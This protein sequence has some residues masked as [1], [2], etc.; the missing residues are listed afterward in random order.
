MGQSETEIRIDLDEGWLET[1]GK[2][3]I[4]VIVAG[5]AVAAFVLSGGTLAMLWTAITTVFSFLSATGLMGIIVV[6]GVTCAVAAYAQEGFTDEMML[7]L[8]SISPEEIFKG[9][10]LLFDID[11]F[12]PIENYYVRLEDGTVLNITDYDDQELVEEIGDKNVDSYFYRKDGKEVSKSKYDDNDFQNDLDSGEIIRTSKQNSSLV[13]QKLVS[14]WYNAIRNI[15]IV[16]SMSVLLYIGIRMLLSTVSQD[17]ARY[18][19]MLV[20]WVVS[21]CLLFFM[22]YIMAFSLTVVD[23]ITDILNIST[24]KTD[25]MVVLEDDEDEKISDA[26]IDDFG[27]EDSVNEDTDPKQI[28]WNTNLMG[29]VRIG[30]QMQYGDSSFVGLG[31]CFLILVFYTVYFTFVYLRRLLY[32]AFLTMIAPLVAL[33]YPI[34]KI[35]DG[36]AQAFDRWLKEYIFNLL[37]QPLH[38]LLYTVLVTSAFD[39]AGEN[40]LYCLVAIGFLI[41]AE[42]LMRSFF[43]FEKASTP[44]SMAGAAVGAGLVSSGIQKLLHGG[45]HIGKNSGDGSDDGGTRS[46]P[47]IG[48]YDDSN[49]GDIYG[50]GNG[51]NGEEARARMLDADDERFGTSDWDPQE[52]DRNARELNNGEGM[53]YSD[54]EYMQILRDSGYTNDEIAQLMRPEENKSGRERGEYSVVGDAGRKILSTRPGRKIAGATGRLR[55]GISGRVGQV[56]GAVGNGLNTVTNTRPAQAIGRAANYL[57]NSKEGEFVKGVGRVAKYTAKQGVRKAIKATPKV[58]A[59]AAAGATLA[60]GGAALGIATGDPSNIL[61]YGGGLGAAGVTLGSGAAGSLTNRPKSATQIARERAFYGD[62]YDEHREKQ[63]LDKLKRDPQVREKLEKELSPTQVKNLV[64]GDNPLIDQY[65]KNGI[66]DV[67][68]IITAEKLKT[69]KM[70]VDGKQVNVANNTEHAIAIVKDAGRRGDLT[71]MSTKNRN[72]ILQDDMKTLEA[73]GHSKAASERMAKQHN[74]AM[75]TAWKIRNKL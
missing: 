48:Y 61:T 36:Q 2:A 16:L 44:G 64:K 11:F 42:K 46:S 22:H 59:G 49:I 26:L 43:G 38:L 5:L 31:L 30:A 7:P 63:E 29:V 13:L 66:T 70:T 71:K 3:I 56:R 35:N 75:N 47:K 62:K 40:I 14:Q 72:E 20:D 54:G 39:L 1:I 73:R 21:L 68:D 50:D 19:Q 37:L 24:S 4:G 10:I 6:G 27:L 53:Q 17:K 18:R 15:A 65:A 23:K 12:N 55:S 52:R 51:N 58:V 9:D 45:P 28:M 33:T 41:P 8:Y 74:T 32:M 69:S 67:K 34:D 60:L 57:S 25:R